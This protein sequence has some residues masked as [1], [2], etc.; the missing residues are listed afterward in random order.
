M[1]RVKRVADHRAEV[2]E[3]RSQ[4]R[5]DV[6]HPERESERKAETGR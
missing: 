6:D 5:E 4:R 1:R 2:N 3:V